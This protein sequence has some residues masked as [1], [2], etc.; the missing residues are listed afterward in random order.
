VNWEGWSNLE[1]L[2]RERGPDE[3]PLPI[4]DV[5]EISVGADVAGPR[6]G[7]VPLQLRLGGRWRDLPFGVPADEVR[8]LPEARDVRE[9]AITGGLGLPLAGGRALIDVG[10]QR[11]SR[12]SDV[13]SDAR[14]RAWTLSVGLRVRP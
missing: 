5:M 8:D 10:V 12:S 6:V 2:G 9:T 4:D 13:R 3:P 7:G 14:E 11:A 1:G